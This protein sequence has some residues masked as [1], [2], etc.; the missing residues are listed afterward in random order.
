MKAYFPWSRCV[1]GM[2]SIDYVKDSGFVSVVC[3]FY[4]LASAKRLSSRNDC[5]TWLLQDFKEYSIWNI[6]VWGKCS[7]DGLWVSKW[8]LTYVYI[9]Y[10]ISTYPVLLDSK[11]YGIVLTVIY[12]LFPACQASYWSLYILSFASCLT[13]FEGYNCPVIICT[14]F[15]HVVWWILTFFSIHKVITTV[16]E[17]ALCIFASL[18]F[19]PTHS[20]LVNIC[21]LLLCTGFSLRVKLKKDANGAGKMV[22]WMKALASLTDDLSSSQ[23]P[24]W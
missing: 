5:C 22:Q 9:W 2:W 11:Q 21:L 7:L 20:P 6:L 18:L 24:S 17:A 14:C 16:K 1:L 8:F 10:C 19:Q 3:V 4:F 15:R 13:A 23:R 12:W